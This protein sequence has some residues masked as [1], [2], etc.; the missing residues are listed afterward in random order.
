MKR[1]RQAGMTL[2]EVMIAVGIFALAGVATATAIAELG[3]LVVMVQRQDQ[4][5]E[6]MRSYLDELKTVRLTPG[7]FKINEDEQ[8]YSFEIT[9]EEMRLVNQDEE[10]LDGVYSVTVVMFYDGFGTGEEVEAQYILYQPQ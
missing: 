2:L 4:L 7:Q 9:V 8:G 3:D 6:R 1:C 5:R 10:E